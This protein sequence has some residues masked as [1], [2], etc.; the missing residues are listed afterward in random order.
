MAAPRDCNEARNRLRNLN[1]A[2][3][4]FWVLSFFIGGV[5]SIIGLGLTASVIG[6]LAAIGITAGTAITLGLIY[7]RLSKAADELRQWMRDH[8]C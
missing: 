4:A 7:R 5:V 3:D 6:T 1:R 2:I 8:N